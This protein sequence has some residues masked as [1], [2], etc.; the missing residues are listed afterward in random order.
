[1]EMMGTE[2]R[3]TMIRD[4]NRSLLHTGGSTISPVKETGMD[5]LPPNSQQSL[6]KW[7]IH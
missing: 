6:K 1:M 5:I 2:I 3:L 4:Y 7:W